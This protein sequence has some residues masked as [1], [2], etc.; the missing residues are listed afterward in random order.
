MSDRQASLQELLVA[1]FQSQINNAYTA[2][3]C[4]V[5]AVRDSLNGQ[6]VDI[7][8]TINQKMK[9]GTTKE[10]PVILGVPV[11][12]QVSNSSG[13][14][15]P[16]SV[17]D[18]GMA[19]F[20]MRSMEAWKGGNGRPATPLN[21]AKMDKSDAIFLPGIQPP[22]N[23]VNNPAKRTWP[24]STDDTVLVHNIGSGNET[25]IRL[26]KAGGI[27]INTNQDVGVNCKNANVVAQE[28]ITLDCQVL[29]V[30][31]NSA[32]MDINTTTWIGDINHTGTINNTGAI[33]SNTVTLSTHTHASSPPPTPG[34]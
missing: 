6:M 4:I 10:R 25:E 2:L 18:T 9:D 16:I 31:A 1:S 26:L 17:G 7:Q 3:P 12:F 32:T 29:D 24:H 28:N 15:F 11:S 22:G 8:P 33:T 21:Y 13:L 20:S 27:V 14:T 34:T 19:I 30:T 5:V 23:A